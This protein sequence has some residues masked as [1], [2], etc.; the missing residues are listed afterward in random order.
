MT[1]KELVGRYLELAGQ[2]GRAVPLAALG[3]PRPE[4]ERWLGIFDE[5]YHI[6]R[7]LRFSSAEGEAFIIN[8]VPQTH[9]S[10]EPGIETVL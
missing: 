2:Y 9:L 10:I 8:G 5:D 3:L 4:L 7:Y 1:L 6:S